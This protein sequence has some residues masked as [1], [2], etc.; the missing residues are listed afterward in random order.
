MR[1]KSLAAGPP[2]P[3]HAPMER[4]PSRTN[5]L[6]PPGAPMTRR[7]FLS[8]AAWGAGVL[9]VPG[10]A[11]AALPPPGGPRELVFHNLH[12]NEWLRALYWDGG[13]YLADALAEIDA[14]LRDHRTGEI[15]PMAP[16]L[17]D[18]VHALTV[19]L[20]GGRTVQ[21]VSGYR[22][23]AT[24][25]LLRSADPGHIAEHS[26]H[27]SGEAI[28]LRIE[29]RPL[30]RVR[31]AALALGAGGVGYYPRSGFVHVDIGRVRRW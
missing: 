10:L 11:A 14:I 24:N 1:Q 21:I 15:R 27:L 20:G 30:R 13:E 26:L 8:L 12:T 7:S 16:Q 3:Y 22:S 4:D 17:L 9:L 29:G 5:V 25:E 18:L 19:R 28:D 23:A 31:D 2:D 6:T